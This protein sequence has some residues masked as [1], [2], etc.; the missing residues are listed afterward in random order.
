ML[1]FERLDSIVNLAGT[2]SGTS[3]L[4]F[5]CVIARVSSAINIKAIV[6]TFEFLGVRSITACAG[7]ATSIEG[8]TRW[9]SRLLR[10]VVHIDTKDDSF[11]LFHRAM[12]SIFVYLPPTLTLPQALSGLIGPPGQPR[13]YLVI[14]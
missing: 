11:R 1:C 14:D 2:P 7:S 13:R 10:T 8:F 5:E 6:L 12:E 4:C 9:Y 3:P